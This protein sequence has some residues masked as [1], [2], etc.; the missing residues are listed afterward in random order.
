MQQLVSTVEGVWTYISTETSDLQSLISS[1][2]HHSQRLRERLRLRSSPL[3]VRTASEGVELRADGIA[4][5]VNIGAWRLDIAPKYA[6]NAS[7]DAWHNSI[8]L[9]LASTQKRSLAYPDLPSLSAGVSSFVDHVAIT[10]AGSATRAARTAPIRSY[11]H[12]T[13]VEPLVRGPIDIASQL[14]VLSSRPGLI[15]SGV[16]ELSTDNAYNALLKWA[17]RELYRTSREPSAKRRMARARRQL[18]STSP[19]T[20]PSTGRQPPPRQFRDWY[21][22]LNLAALVWRGRSHVLSEGTLDGS[23]YVV[24][25]ERLFENFVARLVQG[26]AA[27]L[28]DATAR[29]QWQAKYAEPLEGSKTPLYTKPDNVLLLHGR[30]KA[31]VDAK[32]KPL[33][34]RDVAYGRP[35]NADVYQMAASMSAHECDRALLVYPAIDETTPDLR[36]AWRIGRVNSGAGVVSAVRLD[37]SNVRTSADRAR[38]VA[39]V[40]AE[41]AWLV[42]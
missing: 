18:P 39:R 41:L 2:E 7:V 42:Q 20:M 21:P 12:A 3:Q 19:A 30:A 40:A 22:A 24:G 35:T 27:M 15:V 11:R 31:V 6:G 36:V 16:D 4:G 29:A 8:A 23:G 13:V 10:F 14:A 34:E 32:Y 1:V 28:P 9:M 33:R 25:M 37:L 17:G 26:A 5:S 38:L